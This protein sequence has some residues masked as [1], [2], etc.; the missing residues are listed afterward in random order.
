MDPV[1]IP[2]AV[3]LKTETHHDLVL[4]PLL[5]LMRS[6]WGRG[7]VIFQQNAVSAHTSRSTQA[8]LLQELSPEGFWTKDMWLP[9]SPDL[10][11][12]DSAVWGALDPVVRATES[13][14]RQHLVDKIQSRV[15]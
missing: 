1:I 10:T 4:T 8:H 9:S 3:T 13:T 14:S 12:L 7:Q 11:P 6:R 5:A 2:A 15:E